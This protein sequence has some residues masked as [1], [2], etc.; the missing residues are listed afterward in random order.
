[1]VF[2]FTAT[3]QC[4]YC[5][6][7]MNDSDAECEEHTQEEVSLHF[8]RR[9]TS[10]ELCAV[11]ATYR[12]RWHKLADMQDDDWITW[13]YIGDRS[14]VKAMLSAHYNDSVADIDYRQMSVD[15]PNDVTVEE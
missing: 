9:L 13:A 2:D 3:A 8:F 12:Y 11:R 1:M 4:N 7:Y 5:G 6:N 15:A 10:G 14:F